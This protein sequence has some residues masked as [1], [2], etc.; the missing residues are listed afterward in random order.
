MREISI[1]EK[2]REANG[3]TALLHPFAEAISGFSGQAESNLCR[4]RWDPAGILS[5]PK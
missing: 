3:L 5:C 2:H 4:C 1:E